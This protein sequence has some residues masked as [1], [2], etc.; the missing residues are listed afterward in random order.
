MIEEQCWRYRGRC[1]YE[2]PEGYYGFIYKIKDD[3]GKFYIGKK[4]F[5]HTKKRNLTKK[6]RIGTRKR[7]ERVFFDSDWL[8]YWSSCKSL[9]SYIK[10]RGGTHGFTRQILKLCKDKISWTYWEADYLFREKVLFREDCWNGNILC[11]FYKGKI[12]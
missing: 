3:K 11:H 9:L 2:S 1:L 7:V 8:D 5:T 6:E 10:E 4:A 12:Q